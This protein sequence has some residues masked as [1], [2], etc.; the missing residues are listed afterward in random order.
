M[1]QQMTL[2]FSRRITRGK[3]TE[4]ITASSSE[5]FLAV[6]DVVADRLGLTRGELAF[7]YLLEG[8]QRDLGTIFMAE[9][10]SD[11]PVSEFLRV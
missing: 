2:D 9:L 6:F 7:K 11:K 3:R 8:V 10:H 5:E 1:G 4:R